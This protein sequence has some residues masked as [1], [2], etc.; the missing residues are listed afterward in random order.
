MLHSS[1]ISGRS[2]SAG[3]VLAV[4]G[5]CGIAAAD[6][7]VLERLAQV[8]LPFKFSASGS[9]IFCL[10]ESAAE[11]LSYDSKAQVVYVT[12]NKVGQPT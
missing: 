12:G 11:Q 9:P 3:V 1:S 2:F 7:V 6:P 5:W 10:G 4:L 8:Y